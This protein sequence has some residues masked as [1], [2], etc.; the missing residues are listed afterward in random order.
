MKEVGFVK[1]A[2]GLS[3]SLNLCFY[4]L[5]METMR[6]NPEK[7]WNCYALFVWTRLGI[8]ISLLAFASIVIRIFQKEKSI[9]YVA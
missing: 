3:Q 9:V 5:K 2:K 6:I 1:S 7:T 8:L 4:T